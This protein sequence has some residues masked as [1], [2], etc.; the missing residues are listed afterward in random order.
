MVIVIQYGEY[1][2][3]STVWW[4]TVWWYGVL[5]WCMTF[6]A[7]VDRRVAQVDEI[8]AEAALARGECCSL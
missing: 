2:M 8:V 7:F 6:V 3:V 5:V 4:S 1:S